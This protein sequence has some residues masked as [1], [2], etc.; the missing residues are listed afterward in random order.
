M[1]NRLTGLLVLVL[2]LGIAFLFAEGALRFLSAHFLHVFD[3]EMWR[4]ARLVKIES[5]DPGVIEEHL[6]NADEVLMG[7][8]VRTDSHGFRLPDPATESRR[9]PGDR[10][11]IAVGDSVTFGWGAEEGETYPAQLEHLLATTCPFPGGLH[12]TVIN[13]GIGNCNTSM[14]LARYK[15]HIRPLYHPDWVIL[16]YSYNDGEPDAVP[17]TSPWLWHSSLLALTSARLQRRSGVLSDYKQYYQG[18]YEEG[19]PGWENTKRA[20]REFGALLKADRIPATIILMPELHEPKN[21]GPFV[22][23]FAKVAQVAKESG[24][25]VVDPS[26][27]FPPGSGRAYWVSYEDAHPNGRGQEIYA[28]ALLRSKYA[29]P[30][31][32][33]GAP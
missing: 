7:V 24:F 3:V 11:V 28:K 27:D 25:E 2:S 23:F 33:A 10:T 1:K 17:A 31:K 6:P 22:G 20:L 16:G 5:H 13:A 21:F 29:C 8:R 9:G 15:L 30:V 18:L 4:Y 19:R 26:G 12:T 32:P 14:E